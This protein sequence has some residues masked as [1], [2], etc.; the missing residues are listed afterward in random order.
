[1]SL[2]T[3]WGYTVTDMDYLPDMIGETAFNELT[4]NKYAGDVRIPPTI[5]AAQEAIRNYCGWHI[6]PNLECEYVA[7]SESIGRVL[8]LP[9][10]YV[11]SVNSVTFRGV[12][13]NEGT[14]HFKP[15][16]LLY[17]DRPIQGCGWNDIVVRY[18]AGLSD[19]LMGAITELISHRV[20]HALAQSYGVQSEAAGGVSVTYNATWINRARATA[21]PDDNKEVLAP[22]KLQGVF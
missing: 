13:L 15:N 9:A 10:R 11:T 3:N 16:G 1:M 12:E 20:T 2:L 17:F 18:E 22:Y 8:Q 7:D 6:S 4:A 5:K 19:E 21:L 14:Y